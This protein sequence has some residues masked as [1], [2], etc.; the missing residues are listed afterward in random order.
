MNQLPLNPANYHPVQLLRHMIP[1]VQVVPT[2][3][4]NQTRFEVCCELYGTLFVGHG[5]IINTFYIDLNEK[6]LLFVNTT[7]D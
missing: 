7:N 3:S 5:N 1:G 4:C 2:G 6:K